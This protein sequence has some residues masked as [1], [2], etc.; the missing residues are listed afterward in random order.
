[1]VI[2]NRIIEPPLNRLRIL[3]L[4]LNKSEKAH[5]DLINGALSRSWDILL[6]QE[7]YLTHLGHIR[8]PNG[9]NSI[10]PPDRLSNHE[11]PVRSVI[12]VSSNLSSNSWKAISI[13]GSNDLTAVQIES[14]QAKVTIF[15]IYNDCTHS[16]T[17]ERLRD[18]VGTSRAS[19]LGGEH[20]YMMWCGDF[21]R[22]HPLWDRD[23]D[24]RLFTPQALRDASLLIEIMANEG[25]EMALPKGEVT[26]KHMVTNLYSRPDNVW[27]SSDLIHRVVRCEVD[28]YIQPPCTDHLPIVTIL[29]IPQDRI[30]PVPS[31]NFRM[32]DWE[33]FNETLRVNLDSIP[34]PVE[35]KTEEE[36][37]QAAKDLTLAIQKTI[38]DQVQISKPCPH[39]KRWWSSDLQSMKKKLNK[40]STETTRQRAMPN[41]PC[42]DA[43]KTLARE[44]GNAI[45]AAKKK[46]WVDFLEEASDRDLWTSNRYLKDPV[47][48]G[49]KSRIPTLKVKDA[50]G[51]TREVAS[52]SEKAKVFHKVFFPPRPEASSVPSNFR[53]PDPLPAPPVI[54]KAQIRR[55]I[56]SLSAYKA[57]GPDGIPNVVLQK[58][59]DH[60][61][62]FLESLFQAI[63]RLGFYVDTWREFTTVVLRKPGKPNY[64]VPKAHRPI[65]LLCTMAKVLT[66]I[67]AED[68][69]YLVEKEFLLPESHYG[70]RPGRMTTD[71]VHVLVD[72]IKSAWRKG[73]VVSVL[74]L[75][76]EAA[77][78][79]A[80]TDRLIHNLRRRKIPSVYIRFVEQLL[81]GRRTRM[82]FDDFVSEIIHILNGIGQGDP[83]SMI[84]YIIY[85]A[86]LLEIARSPKEEAL[87]FVDDA[88]GMAEGFTLE[89]NIA[90]LKD[91]M[92]REGGG[93]TWSEEHNSN[94]AL[95]KLAITHFTRRRMPDP[96]R[97]GR[98]KPPPAP[99]L[100]LRNKVVRDE[101][102]YKYLGIHL[103][104][105]LS[106]STQTHEAI[107][108]ATKWI[109]LYRRLTKPS[110]GL[111]ARFMRRL[112]IT[113]AIPKMTY[114]LD[115]W[116]TPP[117][118]PLGG[119]KNSGSVKALREFSKLQ[120]LAT[121]AINGALRTSPTDLLDA[122]AG[123]L[124]MDLL[125]K[126]ICFRS[127][128]RICTLPA[129][130]PVSS[131]AV[132]Y[133]TKPAKSHRTNI[134]QLLTLFGTDPLILE[135]VPVVTRPPVFDLPL[136]ISI[137]DSK[138]EALEQEAKDP[139]DIRIYSDGS[140]QGGYVG[141][142]A[143][144]YQAQNGIIDNP[145]NVL[146]CQLGPDTEYSIWDAE[147]AGV[148]M[149]LWLLRGLDRLSH[150]TIS[151]YSDSQAVLKSIRAQR[152]SPGYHLVKELTD[153]AETLF[154]GNGPINVRPRPKLQWIAAHKEAKGNEK[155]DEE[156]KKA[157]QGDS[158][159]VESLP[160]VLRSSLPPSVGVTKH[161]FLLKLREEWLESWKRSPRRA[162]LEK[163][164]EDFPFDK[165]R[166]ITDQL[167]RVQSSLIFQIRSNHLPLNCYLHKIGK[168]PSKRC[169]QCWRRR[170]QE[171]TETVTH[172]LFE[173]PS[174]DYERHTLDSKL[175]RS[176]R[177][178]K[179]I[180]SEPD[181]AR[182][183]LSYIGRTRRF[184][185]LGDVS[186]MKNNV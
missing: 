139:A 43:R 159:P 72:K 75:D 48:D 36:I 71:A 8:A 1:M 152:A 134:Q 68:I 163:I 102:T 50:N 59:I 57:S 55:H 106:W 153:L 97:P 90:A 125:L 144:L 109:L 58:T 81:K 177:D 3:Q 40:L 33:A 165:H 103:D 16:T 80:V 160:D 11:A 129:S 168:A 63:I 115:V 172:F 91:F 140:C 154:S 146:R 93:F 46:H 164:D 26:L 20:S 175:G 128:M 13:S 95:D 137:A 157:A 143:V 88:L 32:V 41:H 151:L 161:Q 141:A 113:V 6:I 104:S 100:V 179:K 74:F 174:Y 10:F 166:K 64:E 70:G 185:E 158:S 145:V 34:P 132:R 120:R 94:F 155:A 31:R 15:N 60:T 84:L 123:L 135:V 178:L 42:H 69:S 133:F 87:G 73:K 85:N 170:R 117:H 86:D 79:N 12:W 5:L 35:L 18:F 65:A 77:F 138:E 27:C 118:K 66:A 44:Y 24:E 169:E 56:S 136:D 181:H 2:L 149:S 30:A 49:G 51:L 9:F 112:Y 78:P 47:G 110:L 173:C 52:N 184:K 76:V 180:L 28:A 156:A 29:E 21:N 114:G 54:T 4:N 67:V 17:L 98:S 130:N 89:D 14:G 126:K 147:A 37:Q 53:Y 38:E 23:E 39:S 119:K 186:I 183:L 127:L 131:Q 99:D 22:H 148:I 182:T 108:K 121:V 116:Y 19:I 61:E 162:R 176:S 111:S 150:L 142:S 25:M 107:A 105:K 171:V 83:L 167:T 124:P 96:Q 122:H 7:P 82:K 62:D 101:P 45:L 92:N